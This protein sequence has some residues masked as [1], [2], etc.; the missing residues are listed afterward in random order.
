M[1]NPLTPAEVVAAMGGPARAAAQAG[2]ELGEW[3]RTQLLSVYSATRHLAAE[4]GGVEPHVAGVAAAL[5]AVLREAPRDL[6]AV[7]RLSEL[8]A[9]LADTA[10]PRAMAELACRAL[11]LLRAD[12]SPAAQTVRAALRAELARAVRVEVTVLADAIEGPQAG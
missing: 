6:A 9:E 2:E 8:A 10:D 5:A 4:L 12:R 11:D 3:Q 7:P 1:W